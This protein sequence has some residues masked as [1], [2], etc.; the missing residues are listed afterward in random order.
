MFRFLKRRYLL[1][2]C[3]QPVCQFLKMINR[4]APVIFHEGCNYDTYSF[5]YSQNCKRFLPTSEVCFVAQYQ[6]LALG[7]LV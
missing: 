6:V 7:Y 4:H 3:V 1:F 2:A 5:L